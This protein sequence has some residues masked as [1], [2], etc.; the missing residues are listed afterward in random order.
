[1]V[2]AAQCHG[3]A[4]ERKGSARKE[5]GRAAEKRGRR[6]EMERKGEDV[7][8][9]PFEDMKIFQRYLPRLSAVGDFLSLRGPQGRGNL[10]VER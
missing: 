9:C 7:R 10:L 6:R 2:K 8:I 5:K 4:R 3:K 1:M